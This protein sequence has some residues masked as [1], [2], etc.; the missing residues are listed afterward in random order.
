MNLLHWED[1]ADS[2]QSDLKRNYVVQEIMEKVQIRLVRLK[3]IAKTLEFQ[4]PTDR[5][6]K[7]AFSSQNHHQRSDC[8][9]V[10]VSTPF[11][12]DTTTY[13]QHNF[14]KAWYQY[15]SHRRN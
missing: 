13:R 4:I 5:I 14:R 9:I 2:C 11:K 6:F 7:R 1:E 8:Q 3:F 10:P 12:P 15:C